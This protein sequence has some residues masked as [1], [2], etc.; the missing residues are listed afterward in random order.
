[1]GKY[2]R[3]IM[4]GGGIG[5]AVVLAVVVTLYVLGGRGTGGGFFDRLT[6]GISSVTSGLSPASAACASGEDTRAPGAC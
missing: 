3:W 1:M 4:I 5:V 6:S 2:Q